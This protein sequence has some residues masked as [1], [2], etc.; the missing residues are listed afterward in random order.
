MDVPEG[1]K[2][3]QGTAGTLVCVQGRAVELCG[4]W[5]R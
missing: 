4:V 3:L 1:R 5:M 2:V